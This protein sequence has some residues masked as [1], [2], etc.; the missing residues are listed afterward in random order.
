MLF[1]EAIVLYNA[2]RTSAGFADSTNSNAYRQLTR[3]MDVIGDIPVD[4][5]SGEPLDRFFSI[6]MSRGLAP[7]TLNSILYILASYSRWLK[8]RGYITELQDLIGD[9]RAFP[10]PPKQRN[11]VAAS[12][13]GLLLAI[14]E[15]GPT[16]HRDRALMSAA[17]YLMVRAS[18][19][20]HIK[21][22]D[23]NLTHNE[24][25]VLIK[26][27][28]E[29]DTMPISEELHI[30]LEEWLEHYRSVMGKLDPEW[31]LFPRYKTVAY[32]QWEMDPDASIGRPQLVVARCLK[33]IGWKDK[34]IG[35]HV[36]RRSSARA[37]FEENIEAG[38]DSAMREIQ[39]W[40]HHKSI[41]TTEHYL[42]MTHDRERRNDR[43]K[44]K[45]MYPSVVKT[46][47]VPLKGL[48]DPIG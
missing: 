31:V 45:L 6:E 47:V 9:R 8:R 13:F 1:S 26:K 25:E 27:T 16:G 20:T 21:I 7:G 17:L 46:K 12:E 10:D 39:T 11:Y 43:T 23:V 18:E 2:H 40:L 29:R 37:R 4:T 38:Y 14:A 42:G 32:H 5:I 30:E 48:G 3:I 41:A 35:V 22:K 36:L 28:N 34:W 19:L 33:G 24:V 15:Q 44:G